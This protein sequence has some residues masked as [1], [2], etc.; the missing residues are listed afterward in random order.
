MIMKKETG[1]VC[2][3]NE[4]EDLICGLEHNF[5]V[6]L[7]EVGETHLHEVH[8]YEEPSYFP[9]HTVTALVVSNAAYKDV[10]MLGLDEIKHKYFEDSNIYL[11]SREIRRKDQIFKIFNNNELYSSFKTDL[12]N[13]FKRSSISLISSSINKIKLR[14]KSDNFKKDTGEPYDFG[15]IYMKNVEFVLERLGHFLGDRTAKIIFETRGRKESKKIQGVLN[16][17]KENGN[18]YHINDKFKNIDKNILFF[19]KKD[20]INGLQC[21]DYCAYPFAKHCKDPKNTK[22]KH[23]ESLREHIY[24]GD[25]GLYG[26]KE[27]P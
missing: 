8:K 18:W 17:L 3:E 16:E 26:L 11:H 7:D 9:V 13:L 24:P 19:N 21:V 27:W 12:N 15:D 2:N 10:L 6:F 14:K 5:I 20:N 1:E 4:R 23:F 25:Y 22:N